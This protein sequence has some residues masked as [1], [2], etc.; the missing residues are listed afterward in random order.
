[1]DKISQKQTVQ[2]QSKIIGWYELS[3]TLLRGGDLCRLSIGS[4]N[5]SQY[6]WKYYKKRA[7]SNLIANEN[8]FPTP[9]Y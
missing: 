2:H 8:G 1:M 3:V 6:R 9:T 5:I 4:L 7:E